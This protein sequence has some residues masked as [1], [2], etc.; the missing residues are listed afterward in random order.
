MKIGF[1]T[2]CLG[3]VSIEAAAQVAVELGFDCLEVG[4]TI[5]RDRAGWAA[6]QRSG[7]IPIQSFI[8][9]RNFMSSSA[10]EREAYHRE[11][12]GLIETALAIGVPQITMTTGANPSLTLEQNIEETLRYWEPFFTQGREGPLRFAL[13]FCPSA[14][15]FA[16]GPYAWRKLLQATTGYRNFGLNYDPSHLLW[17]FID[18]YKPIEEFYPHLFSLHAKD[19]VIHWDQLSER[20]ILRPFA[21]AEI[22][23]QDFPAEAYAW[24]EYVLPGDGQVDWARL[25]DRLLAHHFAGPILIEHEARQYLG[26]LVRVKQGLAR[27]LA[28]VRRFTSQAEKRAR[29]AYATE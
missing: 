12:M 13:E 23:A 10:S 14:G 8:Y 4:P 19:T 29:V 24:W 27:A 15:N 25:M 5:I 11:L 22:V 2:N 28:S 6:L 20:G 17:Q 16:L 26:D 7:P 18:P 21:S 1:V 3:R 9:G